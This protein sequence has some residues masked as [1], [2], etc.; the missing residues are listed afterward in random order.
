MLNADAL[1]QLRQLKSDIEEKK[2]V[3]PG[4][5]KATNGRF[6]FVALDEGRDVFLPPEE[7]Q[8]VL[9]GDRVSIT[10]QEGDKGK[11]QGVVDELLETSLDTFVGRYLV[12]GKGHFVVPETPGIN[13]WIFI[14]P[15][16]RLNAEPDD[17]IYCR[18]HKHP[19]KDGKGQAKILKVIGK[20]GETGIER[21]FTVATFNLPDTWP[22]AVSKQAEALDESVIEAK[23]DGREDRTEQPYVTID[24]PGTQD[25]DDALLAEPNATGWKLS[26]AIADP[27]AVIEP[28]SPAEQEAFRRATAIYFPGEPLPMLPDTLSTRLCS[29]MPDVKRLAL[30]CD[31]QVNNDGSLGDYSYHKAVIRSH[32][33]LSYELVSNLIEGREADDVKA[34]TDTVSNSLDQ[35]HQAATALR[36]WRNE[37]ALV[38]GDR[39]EFRL[40]LDENRRVRLIEPS[41]QNEAHRLVEECMI[42]ANRC[43][44]DFLGQQDK[45]LFIQH[46]G[47]RDDRADNIRALLEGYAP[48]LAGVDATSA[49]GFRDLMKQTEGLDSEVPVKAI[50]SRQLARAEL[51]FTPAPHQGMGLAAYT[52][53]TS[54]LRKFSDFHVHRLIKSIL[55]QE[56]LS[57]LSEEQLAE[58]QLTQ[59]RARQ[60]ANSLESWLKSD[61]ART[62]GEEAM[63]GVISRT[64]PSGFFVRL[65]ANGL[66]GFVSCKTLDGKFSFDPVTMRLVHNKNGRTFQLEQAVTVTFAG[67]DDERKQI[68]FNLVEAS[69]DA[70]SAENEPDNKGDA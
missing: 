40:R 37:H 56:P 57:E 7:M 33:K 64:T 39:P 66:E 62:L 70:P 21:S 14:P 42:A 43:T 9:P 17:Y 47:L 35:L 69:S 67:V 27:T 20:A 19:I 31:L 1:S 6:G 58:L 2:V 48:D 45:G 23:G 34:L 59:F 36:K 65:D 5:V 61:F 18:I 12:R 44:A 52:T 24:S 28:G 15:K 55:W 16:E 51:S 38:N 29:L 50:I 30:V 25:M 13:R 26:I 8:K 46:P 68:L 53:F 3:F 22:E 32:G 63:T 11:T 10:E 49:E 41:V 4:T 54:P 60:A